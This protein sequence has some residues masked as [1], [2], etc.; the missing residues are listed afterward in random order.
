MDF[1]DDENKEEKTTTIHYQQP[2][3]ACSD[4][5]QRSSLSAPSMAP[6]NDQVQTKR[7]ADV[8][9]RDTVNIYKQQLGVDLATREFEDP[10]KL[11]APVPRDIAYN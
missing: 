4:A 9:K 2:T 8:I 6:P 3:R 7:V 10:A 11:V 5:E 1:T